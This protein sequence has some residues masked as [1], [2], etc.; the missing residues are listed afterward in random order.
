MGN[1]LI[2]GI[3]GPCKTGKS[4]LREGLGKHGYKVKHIAQEHSHIPS[5]W[6]KIANPDVLIYLSVSY[7]KTL[8]RSSMSWAKA[9]Y[10]EQL[11]RLKHAR[12]HADFYINTDDLT[13]EEVIQS[14]LN[15]LRKHK[16]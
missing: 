2:I 9:E 12:Q 4:V 11:K 14:V 8:E 16:R 7:R 10:E 1:G 6:Q 15:F 5:M 3:V 13:E